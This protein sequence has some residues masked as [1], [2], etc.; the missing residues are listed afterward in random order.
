[1]DIATSF[2]PLLQV[3]AVAMTKPTA[4]S[5]RQLIAGW[6]FA[7]RRTVLGMVRS[8]NTNKHH[9][10]YHRIFA[11]A[12][13][14]IDCVGLAL[15]DLVTRCA[16]QGT[17]LLA[18]DDTTLA[19]CGLKVF[20]AGMHRD[21]CLSSRG[22]TVVRWG[23]CWVVLCIIVSSRRDP[24]RKFAIPI[25]M[26]LYLN[27]KT[28]ERL[29]RKHRKKTDLM[30]EMLEQLRDH[31][32]D[33][34]LHFLGDSAYTGPR[35]LARIPSSIAVTGRIGV[36]A[37]L[38]RAPPPRTGKRGRPNRRG[39]RLPNPTEMLVRKGL[40]RMTLK[41]YQHSTYSVRVATTQ[42]RLYLAPE[43]PVYVVAIEHLRGGR[44]VEVF[45]TTE[46][47][48]VS[49]EQVLTRYS[50]RWP[51]ETTFQDS[52]QH[53]GI[54]EAQNR[55]RPAARRTAPA[56]FYLYG[57]IIIW[58]EYLRRQPGIIVRR[59]SGKRHHSFAD[60]LATLRSDSLT[61]TKHRIFSAPGIPPDAHKIIAPL[62]R[63]LQ[64]AA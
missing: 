61:E 7:P 60:M 28:N 16:P 40:R 3:F 35:M 45:Y 51:I 32:P 30:V 43:R 38:H 64:L 48:D 24:K 52:K 17:Y 21:A 46:L 62:E 6:I 44:G 33:E 54:N 58:H 18:G 26:R 42:C 20:G 41:L 56:G 57:L 23:H 11:S 31:V 34:N 8:A 1:M 47:Q 50:L 4:E 37:R 59:W 63:L 27:H 53:L 14:S 25:L 36:D 55:T 49:A 5:L 2:M 22:H 19:R 12:V 9:S 15:F 10:A 29:R 39:E 13:W